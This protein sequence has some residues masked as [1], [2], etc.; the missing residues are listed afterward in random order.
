[1][2]R[3]KIHGIIFANCLEQLST[4]PDDKQIITQKND[5]CPAFLRGHK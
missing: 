1:M 2:Y 4:K 3:N 5:A